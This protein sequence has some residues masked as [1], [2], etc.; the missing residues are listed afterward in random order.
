[1]EENIMANKF[2]GSGSQVSNATKN[3]INKSQRGLQEAAAGTI[4][5]NVASFRTG[6]AVVGD[7]EISASKVTIVPGLG[8]I[9]G[10]QAQVFRSGSFISASGINAYISGSKLIVGAR[11]V[12]GS[13]ILTTSDY[14]NWI[15]F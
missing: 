14:V 15:A 1:M 3:K 6:S 4:L 13:W 11:P 5:Q 12:A 2:L 8:T 10:Y 7:T 9:T